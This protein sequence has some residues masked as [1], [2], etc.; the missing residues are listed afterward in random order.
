MHIHQTITGEDLF[1]CEPAPVAGREV[2]HQHLF[3]HAARERTTVL[4]RELRVGTFVEVHGGLEDLPGRDAA[5]IE[6]QRCFSCGVCN[7][8]DRCLEHCPEGILLR[9]REG[10]RFNYDYCKGCG[11]C[12]TQCPRGVVVMA[13][14]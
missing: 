5:A 4:P 7:S 11:L 8:C 6:A 13:E 12:A 14:L 3:T 9:D 10:Y 1:P 2:I